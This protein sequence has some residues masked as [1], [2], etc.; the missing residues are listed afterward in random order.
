LALFEHLDLSFLEEFPVFAPDPPIW[1]LGDGGFDMLGWHD[2]LGP[3]KSSLREAGGSVLKNAEF[4]H[5]PSKG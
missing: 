3:R 5:S 4:S 2:D 1:M